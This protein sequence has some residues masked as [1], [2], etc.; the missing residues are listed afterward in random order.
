[1]A[2]LFRPRAN[3]L[4]RAA[5]A[6][7]LLAIVGMA[8]AAYLYARSDLVWNVGNPAPQPIPFRHDLHVGGLGMDCRFCHGGVEWAAY[9][10]MPSAQT[11]LTCHSVILAGAGALAPLSTSLAIEQPIAWGSIHRRMDLAYFHHGIHVSK[12]VACETCHGRIDEMSQ[13]VKSETMSMGWCLDCHRD[14]APRLRPPEAIFS[15]GMS[16]GEAAAMADELAAHYGLSTERLT[17]CS[18]CHR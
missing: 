13:T 11:C 3:R 14:P 12:G 16:E 5:L 8:G 17:D 10:G 18:T 6:A 9:A 15:M 7:G 4:F 1:M 2:Q